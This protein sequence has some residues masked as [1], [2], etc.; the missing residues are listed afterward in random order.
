LI[1]FSWKSSVAQGPAAKKTASFRVFSHFGSANDRVITSNAK[2]KH[3]E[4]PAASWVFLVTGKWQ[5]RAGY[6]GERE[7]LRV[8]A[9]RDNT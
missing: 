3:E 4:N 2:G 5:G 7:F 1:A 8:V 9:V 6:R